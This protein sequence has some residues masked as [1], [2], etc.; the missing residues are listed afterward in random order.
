MRNCRL[1]LIVAM[2]CVPLGTAAGGEG[3]ITL[4]AS[5]GFNSACF[6]DRWCPLGVEISNFR[7]DVRVEI[8]LEVRRGG[9][10]IRYRTPMLI[11]KG[12]KGVVPMNFWCDGTGE[13]DDLTVRLVREGTDKDIV[14]PARPEFRVKRSTRVIAIVG[15]WKV[16]LQGRLHGGWETVSVEPQDL[17]R[18]WPGYDAISVLVVFGADLSDLNESQYQA[19]IKWVRMGGELYGIGTSRFWDS[20]SVLN[21]LLP[22]DVSSGRW[23]ESPKLMWNRFKVYTQVKERLFVANMTP[24]NVEQPFQAADS[25]HW[26]AESLPHVLLS[27]SGGR[28]LAV[29]KPLGDG[30]VGFIGFNPASKQLPK[31]NEKNPDTVWSKLLCARSD[32]WGSFSPLRPRDTLDPESRITRHLRDIAGKPMPLAGAIGILLLFCLAIGPLDYIFLRKIRKFH[33]S[34]LT[35]A[36]IVSAF[37]A[38]TYTVSYFGRSAALTAKSLSVVDFSPTTNTMRG[39]SHSVA[40]SPGAGRYELAVDQPNCRIALVGGSG[41]QRPPTVRMTQDGPAVTLAMKIWTPK[42]ICCKW[43]VEDCAPA[44]SPEARIQHVIQMCGGLRECSIV[45]WRGRKGLA[46]ITA[47]N[48]AEAV[49][50]ARPSRSQ[51]FKAWLDRIENASRSERHDGP[52]LLQWLSFGPANTDLEKKKKLDVQGLPTELSLRRNVERGRV[53]LIVTPRKPMLNLTF[54]GKQPRKARGA[55]CILRI[56]VTDMLPE[57]SEWQ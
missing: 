32:I 29:R 5:A 30:W 39:T 3:V 31:P 7:E 18:D 24:K 22:V 10:T 2:L 52:R 15:D 57:D 4:A 23:L 53:Y 1:L 46:D 38:F 8:V 20:G 19:L 26:Q 55:D 28:P 33:Y 45:S 17:P 56:D 14:K 48:A 35:F 9:S 54:S 11:G 40:L 6:A 36:V 42:R 16:G 49:R 44:A 12:F 41:E 47:Q 13:L 43:I 34:L 37:T 51:S 21:K 50:A 25:L 27:T